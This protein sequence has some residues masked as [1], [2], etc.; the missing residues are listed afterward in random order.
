VVRVGVCSWSLRPR[1]PRELGEA[2]RA[3]GAGA[4]QLALGPLCGAWSV[5]ETLEAL[6]AADVEPRSGMIGMRGEDYSTLASIRR[7]GGLR[8]D[9]HWQANLAHAREAAALAAQIGLPLVSFHAGFLEER[10][11]AERA[12]L[13]ARLGAVADVFA[14][15][16]VRVALET[17]Q[18]HA[19]TLLAVLDELDRPGVGVNFD[20]ANMI[21]YGMGD[22][23]AALDRLAPHVL[24][25]HVK[26]ARAPAAPGTWGLEVPAGEGDVDWAAFFHLLR[27]R[28]LTCDLMVER[29]AGADRA[30]DI[31]A[32]LE[33]V[34]RHV[35]PGP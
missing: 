1:S 2:L 33:L 11:A 22:P 23:I 7:T 19:D 34:R 24:Q 27:D 25:I 3:V 35:E 13:L 10:S 8:P 4:V 30:A 31:R 29:E 18:E 28:D 21:L 12:K 17:G 20:P 15:E 32:A 16:G 14:A 6:R 5:D 9:E 26:D